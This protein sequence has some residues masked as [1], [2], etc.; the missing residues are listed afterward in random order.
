[1]C[2]RRARNGK[3]SCHRIIFI[4]SIR[5]AGQCYSWIQYHHLKDRILTGLYSLDHIRWI[6]ETLIRVIHFAPPSLS[7]SI[8]I[9]VTGARGTI[10]GPLHSCER[11]PNDDVQV[12]RDDSRSGTVEL[13][14][15]KATDKRMGSLLAVETVKL[16]YGR[17]NLPSV[18]RDEVEITTG[19]MSV[20]G[21][22]LPLHRCKWQWL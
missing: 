18:L 11:G 3:N 6:D 21:Q 22:S 9:H 13:D 12:T 10:Q 7:I 20:N 4:W 15:E 8:R 19:R 16:E 2:P 14:D 17:C 5:N 1:M